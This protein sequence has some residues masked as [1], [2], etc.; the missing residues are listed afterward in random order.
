MSVNS[1]RFDQRRGNVGTCW[2]QGLEYDHQGLYYI[3]HAQPLRTADNGDDK[4][5]TD[6]SAADTGNS[7]TSITSSDR[8]EVCLVQPRASVVLVPRGH[9]RFCTSCA[10]TWRPWTVAARWGCRY[11]VF[12]ESS[13]RSSTFLTSTRAARSLSSYD[14]DPPNWQ[15]ANSDV[16]KT[17]QYSCILNIHVFTYCKCIHININVNVCGCILN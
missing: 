5:N 9:S 14:P 4:S 1:L 3:L 13:T 8:C 7:T 15:L 11:L 16:S 2:S 17:F 6:D 12:L 10:D